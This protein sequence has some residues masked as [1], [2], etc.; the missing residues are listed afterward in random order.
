MPAGSRRHHAV[1]R[2]A[3]A[4]IRVY[5]PPDVWVGLRGLG[6]GPNDETVRSY[7]VDTRYHPQIGTDTQLWLD[8]GR[9]LVVKGSRDVDERSRDLVL[10]CEAVDTP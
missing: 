2:H 7:E 8:D 1:L 3:A 10:Y 4:A 6:P 5:E 9:C